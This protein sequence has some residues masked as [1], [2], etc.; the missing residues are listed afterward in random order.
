MITPR[1]SVI[2]HRGACNTHYS[3]EPRIRCGAVT[4]KLS[5]SYDKVAVH[6]ATIS[7][8]NLHLDLPLTRANV[9]P[10]GE[11]WRKIVAR[12]A[13]LYLLGFPA[14]VWP[15]PPPAR[16]SRVDKRWSRR[17]PDCGRSHHLCRGVWRDTPGP[18]GISPTH[19]DLIGRNLFP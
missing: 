2:A 10:I 3:L 17:R 8:P 14:R 11:A 4:S 12:S 16:S 5:M 7:V 6:F 9:L 19:R 13:P 18:A 1:K 15:T